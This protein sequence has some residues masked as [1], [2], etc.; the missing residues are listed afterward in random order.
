MGE[1]EEEEERRKRDYRDR[2]TDGLIKINHKKR[3][4]ITIQCT[5]TN[6]IGVSMFGSH[7]ER[8]LPQVICYVSSC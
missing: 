4:S 7:H 2:Q 3:G 6:G 8:G 5:L 1:E